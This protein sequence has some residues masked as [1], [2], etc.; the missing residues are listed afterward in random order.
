MIPAMLGLMLAIA[1]NN[2]LSTTD[3]VPAGGTI[4]V[5]LSPSGLTGVRADGS[6]G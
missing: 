6:V 1:C 3:S 2:D 4:T 5:R